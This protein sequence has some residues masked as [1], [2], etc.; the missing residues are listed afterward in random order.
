MF[1]R[2]PKVSVPEENGQ[3]SKKGRNI[4][5]YLLKLQKAPALLVN[6]KAKALPPGRYAW[7]YY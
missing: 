2:K 1:S 4:N 5:N 6:D 3:R 7:Q